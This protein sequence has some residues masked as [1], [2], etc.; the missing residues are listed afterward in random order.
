MVNTWKTD[1]VVTPADVRVF[2]ILSTEEGT[3]KGCPY[4]GYGWMARLG[5]R[6]WAPT[7][8]ALTVEAEGGQ[9]LLFGCGC[10]AGGLYR[11]HF[12]WLSP[13]VRETLSLSRTVTI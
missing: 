9:G 6:A 12:E 5:V 13:G 1:R 8:G 4:G 3:H 2:S 7:R 10:V 11:S